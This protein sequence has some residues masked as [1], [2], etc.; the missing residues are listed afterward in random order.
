MSDED[1]LA[2]SIYAAV[3]K[4]RRIIDREGPG[5]NGIRLTRD[6]LELLI[7]E[8]YQMRKFS[9]YTKRNDEQYINKN[10]QSHRKACTPRGNSRIY[11]NR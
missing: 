7:A 2:E 6:Y 4:Q 3:S 9:E 1:I 5:E 11:E 10:P 8:E